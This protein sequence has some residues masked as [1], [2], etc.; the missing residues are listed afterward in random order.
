MAR[1]QEALAARLLPFNLLVGM[2][3]K[4]PGRGVSGPDLVPTPMSLCGMSPAVNGPP[5]ALATYS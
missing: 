4:V 3:R 5:Q 2:Q 1:E